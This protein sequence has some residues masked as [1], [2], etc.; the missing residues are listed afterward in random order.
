MRPLRAPTAPPAPPAPPAS[1]ALTAPAAPTPPARLR[2][3]FPARVGALLLALSFGLS[4]GLTGCVRVDGGGVAL[5]PHYAKPFVSVS[6]VPPAPVPTDYAPGV[7]AS[8]AV[9]GAL[10]QSR[11]DGRPVLVEFGADWCVDCQALGR[12]VADPA[13]R[14]VLQ[15]DYRLVTVDIGH[16][17]R[18]GALAARWID[19]KR[20]GIPALVVLN[21]DGTVR[22]TTQ[23]GSFAN[24]RKLSSDD[25]ASRLVAWLY[26]TS[27]S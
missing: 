26:P 18:N 22:A 25:V 5:A 8:A 19:L 3:T 2:A 11:R 6:P 12:R 14:L 23:D 7:D 4:F 27:R 15:R 20:S 13:V 16:Y 21:P 24:A 10:A 9:A 1:P 17:D